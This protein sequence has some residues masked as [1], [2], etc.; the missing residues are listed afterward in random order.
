M[1]DD[2]SLIAYTDTYATRNVAFGMFLPGVCSYIMK[3]VFSVMITSEIWQDFLFPA[4]RA[5]NALFWLFIHDTWGVE[6]LRCGNTVLLFG[7][8]PRVADVF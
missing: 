5:T 4:L 2:E 8:D 3:D 6:V 7:R 1:A